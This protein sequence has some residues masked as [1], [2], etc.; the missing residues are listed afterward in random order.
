[1]PVYGHRD[2][3]GWAGAGGQLNPVLGD[4]G[5]DVKVAVAERKPE[6]GELG[7]QLRVHEQHVVADLHAGVA[8]LHE[9][10]GAGDGTEVDAVGRDA[11]L[12]VGDIAAQRLTEDPR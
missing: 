9:I 4:G 1:M 12:D 8:P 10:D 11:A 6:T 2:E 3:T 7:R 5:V